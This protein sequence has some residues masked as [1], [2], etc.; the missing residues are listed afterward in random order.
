MKKIYI[1]LFA[2]FLILPNLN[3]QPTGKLSYQSVIRNADNAVVQNSQVGIRISILQD[4]TDGNAVYV[5]TQN[6]LTNDN[7]LLSIEFGGQ[8]GFDAINWQQGPYF[9]KT[10]IDI[11]GGSNYSLT[12]VSKLLTV[13]YAIHAREAGSIDYDMLENLPDLFDGSYLSL[14]GIPELPFDIAD[15]SDDANLLLHNGTLQ[16]QLLYWGNNKWQL[17]PPGEPGKVL[18]FCNGIPTWGECV[19]GLMDIDGN[20]YPTVIIGQQEW[21]AENLKTTKFADGTPIEYPGDNN[22]A[23]W[24]ITTGAYAWYDNDPENK[25][26]YG[27]L[28]NWQAAKGNL[29]PVGWRVP[30]DS[31]WTQLVE[32]IMAEY[33]IDNDYTNVNALGNA[34]KSCRQHLSP[35]GGDCA[36]LA[37]PR[38]S[39]HHTHFGTD[40]LGFSGLP[41]GV[42]IPYGTYATLGSNGNWWSTTQ[43]DE[44][45]AFRRNLNHGY[46][47]LSRMGYDKRHGL[48]V[49][50][51][52]DVEN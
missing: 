1:I 16:G 25:D 21:M 29:C 23:W 8:Q 17:L 28:Y 24:N 44:I 33:D 37:H 4:S 26:R 14:E 3:A 5:E 18:N 31:D 47:D 38:W 12:S 51:M 22:D 41:G 46:G 49:R 2:I 19:D 15:L 45:N 48:S 27:A 39:S 43:S 7:G 9:I 36:T 30:E 50:C 32:F 35:L 11:N 10:E 20:N 13:P 42:R 40:M 34:L 52:R 6:P